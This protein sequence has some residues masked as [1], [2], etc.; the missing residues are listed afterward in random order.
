[1]GS[2]I[3]DDI[4]KTVSEGL[5]Y[6][7]DKTEEYTKIGKL[8][9]DIFNINRSKEKAYTRLGR[10]T[11]SLLKKSAVKN[12]ATESSI[13]DLVKEILEYEKAVTA[14]N[15]QV[16][17]IKK[18]AAKKT[19]QKASAEPKKATGPKKAPGGGKKTSGSSAS[20]KSSG[21]S[22]TSKPAS[23]SRSGKS[24]APKKE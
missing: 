16:D 23:G 22:R 7:A 2:S 10:E 20:G 5:G 4:K 19:D 13:K 3:W 1:M 12:P 9:M 21:T 8:K 18:E 17:K 14:L 11:Y 6:A 15:K 24:A